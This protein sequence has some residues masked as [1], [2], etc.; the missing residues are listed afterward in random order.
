MKT[1][2]PRS[3]P[4]DPPAGAGSA[5]RLTAPLAAALALACASCNFAPKYRP[6]P[7]AAPAA[8]KEAPSAGASGWQEAR[9]NDGAIRPDWWRL[10]G[11]PE[12]DALEAQV[13][14]SNQTILAAEANYR[15][16]RALLVQARASYLPT[17][18]GSASLT[19][20]RS[21]Q[22][23]SASQGNASTAGNGT[24]A[25]PGAIVNEYQMPFDASY[26]VDFW[27]R[28]RNAVAASAASAQAS[29]ADLAT[30]I[31]STRAEL[32]EDYFQLRAADEQ[33]RILADTVTSYRQTLDL[34]KTLF[35]SGIDSDEDV[36][37]AQAQY[38]T[39]V[40]QSTDAGVARAEL[41]HA[42][43][44]LI[45]KPPASFSIPVAAFAP[46]VPDIP[47][48]VPS[49]LLERRP[50]IASAERQVAAA[51]A[52]IGIA[53]TAYFPNLSLDAAAG[54]ESSHLARW[55]EWPSRFWSVGPEFS[56]TIFP[57]S[58]LRAANE[59][60]EAAYDQTVANYRQTVLAAF[61]A[62]EDNLAAL[63]ILG[64]EVGQERTAVNSAEHYLTLTLTR[65]R[66]GIDSSLN[67][68]AAETTV[69][70]NR[71]AYIQVRLRQVDASIALV[72][73]LG[74]GWDSSQLPTTRAMTAHPPKWS[75]ANGAEPPAAEALAPANPPPLA[76]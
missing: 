72:E 75:P 4:V 34:T 44:V 70:T 25:A 33:R 45:G 61:Q 13:S 48:G 62:V 74:G 24:V 28:V 11:D 8:Y 46:A 20:A 37:T 54:Y 73:A 43:A 21:S 6:P 5:R 22:T 42:I 53:R 32:A 14:I 69:L 60:A 3:L 16:S 57:F 47:A 18:S 26:V 38:D 27:G 50:D 58:E 55:F 35:Q 59:Q 66:A 23:Y 71:E 31:L 40:A 17:V 64:V 51:N 67:V 12:L 68:A 29:A 15:V 10:Y 30:A 36:A 49:G 1:T 56:G 7:V 2:T 65:F 39:V 52:D 41:E 9:P 76:Q 19:R 63:R